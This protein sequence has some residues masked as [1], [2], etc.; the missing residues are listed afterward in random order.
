M[1]CP[2]GNACDRLTAVWPIL[3]VVCL[4]LSNTGCC[5]QDYV[6]HGDW[7]LGLNRARGCGPQ[8]ASD[9]QCSPGDQCSADGQCPIDG[10][11]QAQA[12]CANTAGCPSGAECASQDAGTRIKRCKLGARKAQAAAVAAVPGPTGPSQGHPRFHPVPTR[13]VFGPVI[14]PVVVPVAAPEMAVPVLPVPET[15]PPPD[16]FASPNSARKRPPTRRAPVRTANGYNSQ[17][18]Y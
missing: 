2:G 18:P 3:F 10:N 5:R 4:A 13:P 11:R 17:G 6:L 8:C 12:N 16:P 15:L 14:Q 7:T 1:V 9:C